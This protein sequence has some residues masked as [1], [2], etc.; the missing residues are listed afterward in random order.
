MTSKEQ[1]HLTAVGLCAK[2]T[3]SICSN[4]SMVVFV[5]AT[6]LKVVE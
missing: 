2:P 4:A 1:C 5:T 6:S 3:D